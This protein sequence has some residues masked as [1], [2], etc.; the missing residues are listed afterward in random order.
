MWMLKSAFYLAVVHIAGDNIAVVPDM[1]AELGY[2]IFITVI[3][4]YIVLGAGITGILA[5]IGVTTGY[6]LNKVVSNLFGC[7]GKKCLALITLMVCIP[8]SSLTGGYFTGTIIQT[9]FGIPNY[10]AIPLFLFIVSLLAIGIG[11]EFLKLSNYLGL[12]L[13]PMICM[14]FLLSDISLKPFIF[15]YD[16]IDWVLVLALAGYNIGG[17]H[18]L[19]VVETSAFLLKKGHKT[20]YLSIFSKV[21]EGIVTLSL[22]YLII[23][24]DTCGPLALLST[25]SK[26]FSTLGS[27]LVSIVMLCIFLNT[28]APAMMVN[29]KQLSILTKI[30]LLPSL[31]LAGILVWFLSFFYYHNLLLMISIGTV[32]LIIFI[33]FTVYNLH[34]HRVIKQ[35]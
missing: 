12:L 18:S 17:M 11:N 28:M 16:S 23:I 29:A 5:W 26:T 6:E 34:K 35:K 25:A 2:Q 13:I 14:L 24:T 3:L 27:Y 4:A 30:P 19:L 33:I 22:A 10:I 8:A 1:A 21:V 32:G 31:F 20:I 15:A 7:L 9:M